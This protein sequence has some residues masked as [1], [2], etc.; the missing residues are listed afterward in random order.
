M[1]EAVRL[2]L[3][4][5]QRCLLSGF[6]HSLPFIPSEL[7]MDPSTF[8]MGLPFQWLSAISGNA[9]TDTCTGVLN[10][11]DMSPAHL[12]DYRDEPPL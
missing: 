2:K 9:L 5:K 1:T 4:R 6:L 7:L 11:P 10:L 8:R 12:T 3:H